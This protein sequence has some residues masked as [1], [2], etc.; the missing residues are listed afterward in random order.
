VERP[1]RFVYAH[2]ADPEGRAAFAVFAA[3]IIGVYL[4]QRVRLVPKRT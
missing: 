1:T 3:A 2:R 4:L